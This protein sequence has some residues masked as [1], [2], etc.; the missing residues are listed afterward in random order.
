M[1]ELATVLQVPRTELLCRQGTSSPAWYC[2]GA[3]SARRGMVGHLLR[4][5][6]GALGQAP[7]TRQ[8]V[9]RS[10]KVF[11]LNSTRREALFGCTVPLPRLPCPSPTPPA[12]ASLRGAPA[13]RPR[14]VL[15]HSPSTAYPALR[16]TPK[17]PAPVL[18][19]CP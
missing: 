19:S 18:F 8:S 11:T 5:D 12:A 13:Q 1:P 16:R 17:S 14:G 4:R 10:A 2:A 7:K 3:R 6:T 9:H 15:A